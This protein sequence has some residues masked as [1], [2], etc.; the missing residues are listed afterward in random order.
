MVLATIIE[1]QSSTY[2]S[3]ADYRPAYL[4]EQVFLVAD[5]LLLARPNNLQRQVILERVN[6]AVVMTQHLEND[7]GFFKVLSDSKIA[8]IGLLAQLNQRD[9]QQLSFKSR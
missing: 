2:K 8:F 7:A 1:T 9:R 5:Q 4:A 6:V 3:L